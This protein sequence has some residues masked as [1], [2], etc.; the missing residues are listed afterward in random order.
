MARPRDRIKV[1]RVKVNFEVQA[2]SA[3]QT[4]A[5]HE[6]AAVAQ[7]ARRTI[8]DSLAR[9]DATLRQPVLALI[10]SSVRQSAEASG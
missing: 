7:V 9:G 1:T 5:D 4:I 10:G 6:D 2:Y 8:M 3:I